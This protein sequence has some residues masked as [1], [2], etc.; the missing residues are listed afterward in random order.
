MSGK[1]KR[2]AG[3]LYGVAVVELA[4]CMPILVLFAFGTISANSMIYFKQSLKITAYEGARVSL[5]PESSTPKVIAQCERILAQ[6]RIKGATVSVTPD[7][8]SADEGDVITVSI[9][10]P[11][12]ENGLLASLFFAGSKYT[13]SVSMMK[14][15]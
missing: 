4:I 14:E 2:N 10:A 13:A 1:R 11:C 3:K 6:R 7:I 15:N 9:E 8:V 5:L 12:G